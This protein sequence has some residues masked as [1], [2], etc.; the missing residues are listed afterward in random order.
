MREVL[1]YEVA[2]LNSDLILI[3]QASEPIWNNI[4]Y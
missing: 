1:V 2:F 3:P 4:L